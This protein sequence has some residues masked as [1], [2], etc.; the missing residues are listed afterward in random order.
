YERAQQFEHDF[1][2]NPAEEHFESYYDDLMM[3]LETVYGL[4]KKTSEVLMPLEE[5][6]QDGNISDGNTR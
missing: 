4:T 6:L 3:T 5:N 2:F 1:I